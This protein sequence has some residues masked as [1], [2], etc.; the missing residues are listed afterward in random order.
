[1]P[2]LPFDMCFYISG[3]KY[4]KVTV[5]LCNEE[6]KEEDELCNKSVAA[7]RMK[8]QRGRKKNLG[9]LLVNSLTNY[10]GN[11]LV[12]RWLTLI[13][14]WLTLI[15]CWFTLNKTNASKQKTTKLN[16]SNLFFYCLNRIC[17]IN[18]KFISWAPIVFGFENPRASLSLSSLYDVEPCILLSKSTGSSENVKNQRSV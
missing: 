1:M 13:L 17:I 7:K 3:I 4:N 6:T 15:I 12:I 9:N 10:S 16:S 8:K 14:H 11:R 18:M 2:I 5:G